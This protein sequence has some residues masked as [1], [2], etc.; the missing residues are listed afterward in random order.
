LTG[1]YPEISDSSNNQSSPAAARRLFYLEKYMKRICCLVALAV[2]AASLGAC[3][4]LQQAENFITSPQT[5]QSIA[6]LKS[7]A[8]AFICA[9]ADASAVAGAI[10]AQPGMADQS[11]IGTDGKVYVTSAAVCTALGGQVSGQGVVP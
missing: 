3:A 5:Q 7:G 4:E 8:A 10:D 6:V 1:N 2:G 9:V 11:M